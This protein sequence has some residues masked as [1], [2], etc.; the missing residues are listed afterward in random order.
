M[1]KVGIIGAGICGLNTALT[2]HKNNIDFQVFEST[3]EPVLSKQNSFL[4]R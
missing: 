4:I 1:Q 2:L 3:N